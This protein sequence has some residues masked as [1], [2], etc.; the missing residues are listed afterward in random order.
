MTATAL[1]SSGAVRVAQ[2]GGVAAALAVAFAAPLFLRPYLV[3]LL[4]VTLIFALLAMSINL[5]AGWVGLISVGHAGIM[6]S[7][8][9]GVAYIARQGGSHALQ[10]AVGFGIGLLASLIFGVMAMRTREVYFLMITLA[11]G[12]IVWGL[13]YRMAGVTGGENGLRGI[14]RPPA[15]A[16]YWNYYYLCVV[17]FL[18]CFALIWLITRSPLGLTLQ[19]LRDSESRARA[20]GYNPAL[21][22][23]YAFVISGFFATVAGVLHVYYDQFISPSV[24]EFL[25]SGIGVLMVI[26]GGVGT[27]IGPLVGAAII[28]WMENV[29]SGVIGRWPTVMGVMFIV[30]VLFARDGLVGGAHRLWRWWHRRRSAYS[31][32]GA[33]GPPTAPTTVGVATRTTSA[34]PRREKQ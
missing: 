24:A 25:R 27:L 30:V 6:A 2:A 17:V 12:M 23:C 10:I 20:L 22:K 26:L 34:S 1:R 15:V 16:P 33:A 3:G 9:Y 5:L 32:Q 31:E 21:Y 28:T 13:T 4:S 14:L 7:A 19:G 29:V 18:A 8:G 11:Q